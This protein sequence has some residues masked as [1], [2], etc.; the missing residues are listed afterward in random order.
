MAAETRPADGDR[1]VA[2]T[3]EAEAGERL[4]RAL[5]AWLPDLTRSAIQ[6]LID[7]GNARVDGRQVKSGHKLRPGERVD[8]SIPLP[9]PT[10]LTPEAIP[11]D[12]VYE[13]DDL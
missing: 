7:D 13:D 2:F 9:R 6:R 1:S 10:V 4:D 5:G 3:V 8:A 12:V 11:L